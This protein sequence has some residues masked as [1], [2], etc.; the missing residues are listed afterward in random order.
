MRASIMFAFRRDPR[1]VAPFKR[2]ALTAFGFAAPD[3]VARR[4]HPQQRIRS[5]DTVHGSNVP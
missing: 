2:S 5:D 1:M 4:V 3:Y